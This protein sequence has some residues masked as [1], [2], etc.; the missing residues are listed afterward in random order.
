MSE[1]KKYITEKDPRGLGYLPFD[2]KKG[3]VVYG[4]DKNLWKLIINPKGIK[5]WKKIELENW[6]SN[7][8][9]KTRIKELN[10][11]GT[12]DSGTFDPNSYFNFITKRFS[13]CQDMTILEQLKIGI[14]FLDI[15]L[16]SVNNILKVFHGMVEE[17]LD[18]RDILKT[19]KKFLK[20]NKTE[21]IFIRVENTGGDENF[22]Y[23]FFKL[24]KEF[25]KIICNPKNTNSNISKLRGKILLLQTKSIN[26]NDISFGIPY[27][28]FERQ[29]FYDLNSKEKS[30]D[31]KF[32]KIL[33]HYKK[34][35]K[36]ENDRPCLNYTSGS[37]SNTRDILKSLFFSKSSLTPK[38]IA[39]EINKR[40]LEY[41]NSIEKKKYI[42]FI[43]AD[44]PTEEL[45]KSIIRLNL[46]I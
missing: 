6:M 22:K 38:N 8:N 20:L 21:L 9:N 5:K 4:N 7:L 30:M 40:N 3:K 24:L 15:R 44:F 12:H 1:N 35:S 39:S 10:I 41:L 29:D 33:N 37:V 13:T 27:K 18:F 42:G 34:C 31:W 23:L 17:N 45:T 46:E 16:R 14:R 26:S 2:E 36:K 11:P 25:D 19:L 28:D 43:I 32:K